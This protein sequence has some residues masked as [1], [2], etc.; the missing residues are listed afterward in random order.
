MRTVLMMTALA[1][2]ATAPA[3]AQT[4]STTGTVHEIRLARGEGGHTFGFTPARVVARPGDVLLFRVVSGSPHSIVFEEADMTPTAARAWSAA[5]PRR[6][7]PLTSP[8]FV[9][10]GLEYPVVVPDVPP[11]RYRFYSLPKLAYDMRGEVEVSSAGRPA[12]DAGGLGRTGRAGS[13]VR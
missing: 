11:G 9:E 5:M 3:G 1:L 12:E 8:V 7:A 10:L 2:A 4:G 13:G 6:V